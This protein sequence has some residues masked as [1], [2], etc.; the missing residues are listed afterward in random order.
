M[1]TMTRI[2]VETIATGG[3]KQVVILASAADAVA[4]Q[5]PA[6]LARPD[7]VVVTPSDLSQPGW[8]YR[9]G[10]RESAIVVGGE[11]LESHNIAAVVTRV[12]WIAEAELPHIV[13]SDRAFV[14]AEM[15]AFLL[16]WLSEIDCPVANRPRPNC[17][18]GPFWRH[19][20]WVLEA[21]RIGLDVEPVLRRA[22]ADGG[23]YVSPATARRTSVT[24]VGERCFGDAD[25]Q[26]GAYALRL[27]RATGVETLTAHFADSGAGMRF[28]TANPWPSLEEDEAA[29]A[30]LD[31]LV[32]RG[33]AQ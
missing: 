3:G 7:V 19:E 14:A 25:G 28:F 2:S 29:T 20:R 33:G 4:I 21:A 13:A 23:E 26:L 6:R 15:G 9:P 1:M 24:V 18:C 8:W 10:R 31:H 30:L 11:R 16:A 32:A 22:N 5:L 27:A 17:L 12:P